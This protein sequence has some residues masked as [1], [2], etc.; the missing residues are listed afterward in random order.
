MHVGGFGT[1]FNPSEYS[2]PQ[3]TVKDEERPD[4]LEHSC[5]DGGGRTVGVAVR[6]G[7]DSVLVSSGPFPLG[8]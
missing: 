5:R 2:Y 1:E 6:V 8:P 4:L 3:E 7:S